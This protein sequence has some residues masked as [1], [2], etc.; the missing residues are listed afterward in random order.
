MLQFTNIKENKST[1]TKKVRK[2]IVHIK[3]INELGNGFVRVEK[4]VLQSELFV[5]ESKK[6]YANRVLPKN[7]ITDTLQDG[8]KFDSKKIGTMKLSS[9]QQRKLHI[10]AINESLQ[11]RTAQRI[12]RTIERDKAKLV[13]IFN[14]NHIKAVKEY[15]SSKRANLRPKK[16]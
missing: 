6:D 12:D 3:S 13:A 10:S 15:K 2:P 7:P 9:S 14:Q 8:L 5:L 1:K 16:A 11:L 4:L